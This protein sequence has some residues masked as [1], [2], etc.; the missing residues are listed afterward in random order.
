MA[1]LSK[2]ARKLGF[3][4]THAKC[5][6]S[7][8]TAFLAEKSWPKT[9]ACFR[10]F[11]KTRALVP[12]GARL[13]LQVPLS[14]KTHLTEWAASANALPTTLCVLRQNTVDLAQAHERFFCSTPILLLHSDSDVQP[15]QASR[16]HPQLVSA[17]LRFA[18]LGRSSCRTCLDLA[19]RQTSALKCFGHAFSCSQQKASA[20]FGS[21]QASKSQ[22]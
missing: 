2:T 12:N 6:G 16:I 4:A 20:M 11:S 15:K 13:F 10:A 3:K 21:I 18:A 9:R 5:S 19:T 8:A 17:A 1:D 7:N 22:S 14:V